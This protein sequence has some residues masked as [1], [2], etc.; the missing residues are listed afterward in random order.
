LCFRTKTIRWK[1]TTRNWTVRTTTL[2]MGSSVRVHTNHNHQHYF[3]PLL[4]IH[5]TA[6]AKPFEVWIIFPLLKI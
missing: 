4:V 6:S 3:R 2:D 1:W 5:R